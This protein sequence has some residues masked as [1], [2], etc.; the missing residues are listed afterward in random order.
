ME[1]FNL[2][3]I[4]I[5]EPGVASSDLLLSFVSLYFYYQL[6]HSKYK[7]IFLGI[8]ISSLFG[9][10]YHAFFPGRF[11]SSF[12]ML[13]WFIV[14][15]G[16]F[17]TTKALL[18]LIVRNFTLSSKHLDFI[19][20][21]YCLACILIVL[22]IYLVDSSFINV[23]ALYFPVLLTLTLL[24][25]YKVFLRKG[26]NM[27]LTG[28]LLSIFAGIAQQ[29]GVNFNQLINSNT[30]YHFLQLASLFFIYKGL[31]LEKK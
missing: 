4:K 14:L 26:N 2:Y 19:F 12:G 31:S 9:A 27:L 20:Y 7:N 18:D 21:I 22:R 17:I 1:Y 6:S 13:V 25:S 8:F 30:I 29:S 10:I 11:D 15:V 3:G 23:I 24:E 5:F 16:I 28:C